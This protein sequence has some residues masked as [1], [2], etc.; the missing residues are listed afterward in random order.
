LSSSVFAL[1]K[2]AAT[3]P[4]GVEPRARLGR[5]LPDDRFAAIRPS[6]GLSGPGLNHEAEFLRRRP[7]PLKASGLLNLSRGF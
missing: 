6:W 5:R 7:S 3:A 1:S 4:S 2:K